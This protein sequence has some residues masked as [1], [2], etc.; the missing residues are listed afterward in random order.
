MEKSTEL[1]VVQKQL[2]EVEK[3]LKH[4]TDEY[5]FVDAQVQ[6]VKVRDRYD[7]DDPDL[8]LTR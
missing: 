7:D 2:E 8:T 4:R 5:K 6:P 1:G 3:E